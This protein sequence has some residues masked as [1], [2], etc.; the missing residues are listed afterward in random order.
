MDGV[1]GL[2]QRGIAPGGTFT[3]RFRID[4]GQAGTFWYHGHAGGQLA[5]GLYGGLVVHEPISGGSQGP[6][7]PEY[8]FL[9]GDWYHRRAKEMME[10]YMD[11]SHFANEVRKTPG[12]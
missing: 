2:T 5:D 12:S 3:Y 1:V 10:W 4:D 8:L 11:S 6:L 9:I 7:D